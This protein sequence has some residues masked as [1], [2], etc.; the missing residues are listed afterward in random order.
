MIDSEE[1]GEKL[2]AGLPEPGSYPGPNAVTLGVFDG[3]HLG[4]QSLIQHTRRLAAEIG[5]RAIVLS[6]LE[7]PDALLSGS[8]PMPLQR[9]QER[10]RRLEALGI[11]A[12]VRI[13]FNESIR[14][15]SAA[16]FGERVLRQALGCEA[17]VLGFDSAIC[18]DRE[19]TVERFAELGFRAERSQAVTLPDG[20]TVSSSRIRIAL[21][22]GQVERAAEM[23]GRAFSL[24]SQV[25]SGERR[26]RELGFPTANF[27]PSGVALPQF[28]V[29]AVRTHIG[30]VW[31]P[32]VANLGVRPSFGDGLEPLLEVHVMD[33][34][35]DLYGREL[36]IAFLARLRDEERFAGPTALK[37]QIK[38]DREQAK[39]ALA[40]SQIPLP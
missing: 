26:G 27:S 2:S 10:I 30:D 36:E 19:G 37:A 9:A 29:Y 33:F 1:E 3:V 23:L 40:A 39:S 17:L 20:E 5:G 22:S 34:Q 32:G 28:G 35:G 7:H 24:T 6:F 31:M 14:T 4:H 13:P 15:M 21:A 25:L 38:R 12:V 8:A 16:E 18:H 11:D